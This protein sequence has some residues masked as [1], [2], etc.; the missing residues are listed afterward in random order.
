MKQVSQDTTLPPCLFDPPSLAVLHLVT[1][2]SPEWLEKN[3]MGRRVNAE[4]VMECGLIL[5][6]CSYACVC[7]W[8]MSTCVFGGGM[9]KGQRGALCVLVSNSPHFLGTWSLTEPRVR[10]EAPF[11]LRLPSLGLGACSTM[12]VF[13]H[14]FWGFRFGSW[15]SYLLKYLPVLRLCFLILDTEPR[16]LSIF[17]FRKSW[18]SYCKQD[19]GEGQR[20]FL[21]VVLFSLSLIFPLPLL[22]PSLSL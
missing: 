21:L 13:S 15:Y 17:C 10:P 11:C 22:F 14:E 3:R 20:I 16:A 7:V 12:L 4:E 19:T 2:L 5:K 6:K 18:V 9:H 8:C 1:L